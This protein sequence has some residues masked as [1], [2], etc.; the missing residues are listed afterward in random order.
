MYKLYESKI[1]TVFSWKGCHKTLS[2][3]D[4]QVYF[5]FSTLTAR[6]F[7]GIE[8]KITKDLVKETITSA[9]KC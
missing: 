9:L 8:I 4:N 7:Y 1:A 3:A 5:H 2:M 6:D